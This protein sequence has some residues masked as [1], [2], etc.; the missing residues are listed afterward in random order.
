MKI[1]EIFIPETDLKDEVQKLLKEHSEYFNDK[2]TAKKIRHEIESKI[3]F[4]GG[5][6]KHDTTPN[7]YSYD[8]S[9]VAILDCLLGNETNAR[10][11]RDTIEEKIGFNG[12][13]VRVGIGNDFDAPVYSNAFYALLDYLLSDKTIARRRRD[14]LQRYFNGGLIKNVTHGNW[15]TIDNTSFAVLDWLLGK[16]RRANDV[17]DEIMTKIGFNGS[18]VKQGMG[19]DHLHTSDSASFAILDYLLGNEAQAVTIRKELEER[20]GFDNGLIKNGLGEHIYA[21]ALYTCNSA[22]YGILCL[23]ERLK[24]YKK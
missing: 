3:G 24:S 4:E 23:A 15:Y 6:A 22:L 17:K 13:L 21:D 14:Y 2:A 10:R 16:E 12:I 9:L 11:I 8:S 18:L 1:P 7:V 20:I 19:F 5:L